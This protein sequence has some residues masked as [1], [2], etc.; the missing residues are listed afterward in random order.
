VVQ[1]PPRVQRPVA[2]TGRPARAGA[3]VA[4][5]ILATLILAGCQYLYGLTPMP[6]IDPFGSFDPGAFESPGPELMP[7]PVAIFESGS[8]EITIDGT[9]TTLDR[10]TGAAAVYGMFGTNAV[11]TDG[12]GLYMRYYGPGEGIDQGGFVSFDRIQG[13]SHWTTLDP[14]CK[15]ALTKSDK[16]GLAGTASCT[17]VRWS[18]AMG[19]FEPGS[20]F[21]EGEP[22]FDTEV[23][24][25]AGP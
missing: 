15:V 12:K 17:N 11:W 22:P 10:L 21:I 8:A 2:R 4:V 23:T 5:A 24:F 18:D 16:T 9:T 25:E 20:S 13:G 19:G 7:S 1:R 14:G 6:P 3:A